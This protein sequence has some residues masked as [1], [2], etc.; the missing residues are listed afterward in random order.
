ERLGTLRLV[1]PIDCN[2]GAP[3]RAG[4]ARAVAAQLVEICIPRLLRVLDAAVDQRRQRVPRNRESLPGVGEGDERRL[5]ARRGVEPH[6]RRLRAPGEDVEAGPLE[7]VQGRKSSAR[8]GRDGASGPASQ[9]A[10]ERLAGSEQAG[11]SSGLELE[12]PAERLV[13]PVE[14]GDS[15]VPPVFGGEVD[16]PE[17]EVTRNV[18]EKVDELEPGADVVAQRDG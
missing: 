14:V 13:R 2:A 11:G 5:F 3:N 16:T 1:G 6:A 18:L 17:C 7:G 4:D 12:Q 15:E 9:P 10:A 8:E